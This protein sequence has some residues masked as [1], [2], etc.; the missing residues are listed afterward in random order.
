MRIMG[1][2]PFCCEPAAVPGLRW[3]MLSRRF[4]PTAGMRSPEF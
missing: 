3:V 2:V 4:N 1:L